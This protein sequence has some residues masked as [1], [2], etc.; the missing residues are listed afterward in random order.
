MFTVS[1]FFALASGRRV[2]TEV[3]RSNGTTQAAYYITY[4]TSLDCSNSHPVS[5][6]L[7]KYS[8]PGDTVFQDET[9]AYVITKAFVPPGHVA[10]NILLDAVHIAPILGDPSSDEYENSVPDFLHPAIFA[11]GTV[12]GD[13]VADANSVVTFPVNVS[14]Y[15]RGST[16]MTT[17]TSA[18]PLV[19]P[20]FPSLTH[21]NAG[22]AWTR[23]V[24]GGKTCPLR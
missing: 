6:E 11:H 21:H 24:P 1:G 2:R 17:L 8:P 13:G 14:D 23:P 22:G 9:V 16:M 19:L 10:A 20:F 4:A 18:F 5:A 3:P 7:R 12:S 15:V